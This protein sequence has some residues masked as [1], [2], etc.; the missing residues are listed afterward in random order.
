MIH[1]L[2]AVKDL[3][4][5]TYGLPFAVVHPSQALRTFQQQ[6]E[7]NAPDNPYFTHPEHWELWQ[8]GKYDDAGATITQDRRQLGSGTALTAKE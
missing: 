5:N 1:F 8:I 4:A 2:C 3:A 6:I 7:R